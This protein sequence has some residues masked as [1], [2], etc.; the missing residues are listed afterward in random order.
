MVQL[1]LHPVR[2]ASPVSAHGHLLVTIASALLFLEPPGY[3]GVHHLH[4][5]DLI[6]CSPRKCVALL[7]PTQPLHALVG[8]SCRARAEPLSHLPALSGNETVRFPPTSNLP[9][10]CAYCS[11]ALTRGVHL[12]APTRVPPPPGSSHGFWTKLRWGEP[13]LSPGWLHPAALDGRH[14][15]LCWPRGRPIAATH[16]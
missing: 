15:W 12:M 16:L 6:V 4:S 13:R 2:E 3:H 9:R 11:A 14:C 1:E 7:F 10:A 5:T 8:G